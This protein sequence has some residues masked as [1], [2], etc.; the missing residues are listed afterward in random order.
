MKQGALCVG[1]S[2]VLKGTKKGTRVVQ[3]E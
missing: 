2:G 3:E 1:G